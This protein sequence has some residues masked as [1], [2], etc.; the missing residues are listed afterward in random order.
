VVVV[1]AGLLGA[2]APA[3]GSS[4]DASVAYQLDAAH[5]GDLSSAV[6]APLAEQWSVKF[7]GSPLLSPRR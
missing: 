7:D 1:L 5:D 2:A 4:S 6:T 3:L